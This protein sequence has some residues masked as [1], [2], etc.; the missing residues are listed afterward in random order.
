MTPYLPLRHRSQGGSLSLVARVRLDRKTRRLLFLYED[1]C[2]CRG[3]RWAVKAAA[4]VAFLTWLDQRQ[5]ALADVR[6]EDMAGYRS[7]LARS[8]RGTS[9]APPARMTRWRVVRDLF[10]FLYCN[11]HLRH[12]PGAVL[13]LPPRQRGLR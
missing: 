2:C 11:H 7:V 8:R 9:Q 6:P 12:D 5:V 4:L 1:G 10:R 13:E 3:R